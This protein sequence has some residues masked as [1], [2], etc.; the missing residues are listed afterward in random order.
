[1]KYRVSLGSKVVV[2]FA[3]PQT[4]RVVVLVVVVVVVGVG[5]LLR[6]AGTALCRS[7][8]RV[9]KVLVEDSRCLLYL[10]GPQL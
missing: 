10:I 4:W 3:S 5:P 2:A 1:M 8:S 6:V 7:A 9:R